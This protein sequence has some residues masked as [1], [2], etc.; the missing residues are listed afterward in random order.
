MDDDQKSDLT[1]STPNRR[2]FLRGTLL[3]GLVPAL[4]APALAD[5]GPKPPKFEPYVREQLQVLNERTAE[6]GPIQSDIV[7]I[8]RRMEELQAQINNCVTN[9]GS[10]SDIASVQRSLQEI[11]QALGIP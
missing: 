9:T 10:S 6:N 11:K 1:I 7:E 8:R 2:M 4:A 5:S 3:G